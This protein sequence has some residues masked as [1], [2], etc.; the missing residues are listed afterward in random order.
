MIKIKGLSKN[1]RTSSLIKDCTIYQKFKKEEY[2]KLVN[3]LFIQSDGRYSQTYVDD[4]V[5]FL[6]NKAIII[7]TKDVSSIKEEIQKDSTNIEGPQ[8][9]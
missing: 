4:L 1:E 5:Y 6:K 2:E 3:D 8:K 9:P 7:E